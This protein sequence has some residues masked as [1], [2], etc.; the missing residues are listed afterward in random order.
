MVHVIVHADH[1]LVPF[2]KAQH[3]SGNAAV[4]GHRLS[5]LLSGQVHRGI[6]DGEVVVDF[7]ASGGRDGEKGR[8]QQEQDF[9]GR[10]EE[11]PQAALWGKRAL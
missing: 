3:R 5:R 11:L 7:P 6:G 10:I 1:R 2:A 9:H 4:D 8:S